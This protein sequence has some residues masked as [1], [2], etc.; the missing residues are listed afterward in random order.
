MNVLLIGCGF[1]GSIY[2]K[3]FKSLNCNLLAVVDPIQE[4]RTFAASIFNSVLEFDD[5]HEAHEAL[6]PGRYDIV[7]IATPAQYHL[8]IILLFAKNCKNIFC[9]KPFTQDFTEAKLAFDNCK[10]RKIKLG[11]GFKMR[12]EEIFCTIKEII[13]GGEIGDISHLIL[14]YYQETPHQEWVRRNG[15]LIESTIHLI[16][17]CRW[18]F[19]DLLRLGVCQLREDCI[20]KASKESFIQLICGNTECVIKNGWLDAYAPITGSKDLLMQ[21]IGSK[22]NIIAARP[23][24]IRVNTSKEE[25]I[26]YKIDGFDY[27]APFVKEWEAFLKYIQEG[28]PGDL[29]IHKEAVINHQII[30]DIEKASN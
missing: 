5:Y 18:Y 3:I 26:E 6:P 12:Y 16:D 30:H 21:V 9:E 1:I 2:A 22:G 4:R 28:H 20:Y 17:L 23:D 24:L 27:E 19:G 11:T 8:E 25:T 10:R 13:E 29:V 7:A 15:I 14:S